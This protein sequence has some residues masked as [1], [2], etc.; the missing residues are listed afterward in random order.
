MDGQAAALV[1]QSFTTSQAPVARRSSI[2]REGMAKAFSIAVDVKPTGRGDLD[3]SVEGYWGPGLRFAS[4]RLSPHT[5][6][7]AKVASEQSCLLISLHREGAAYVSQDGRESEV[8]PGDM[9]LIDP[10]R[11]FSIETG[12]IFTTS[13]YVA[14]SAVRALIPEIDSYTSIAIPTDVGPAALFRAF[15]DELFRIAP[16]LDSRAAD[17]VADTVPFVLA[18]ALGSVDLGERVA[19]NRTQ[20][21][22]KQRVLRFI[23]E[24]LQDPDLDPAKIAQGVGLSSRYVYDLFADEP[25]ALMRRVW[26]ERLERC[27]SEL[28]NPQMSEVSIGQIAFNWGFSDSA[29]FSRTFRQQFGLSPREARSQGVGVRLARPADPAF[30]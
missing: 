11:P 3:C 17:R 19:P 29:H 5:T 28:A 8:G 20:A 30:G 18:T 13:L 1:S 12:E 15:I 22:H 24:N 25:V 16:Q 26:R 14:R 2:F 9:F 7:P 21:A 10:A 27:R 6:Q 23:R 4:L